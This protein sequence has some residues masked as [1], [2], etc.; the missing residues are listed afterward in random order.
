MNAK[1]SADWSEPTLRANRLLL[2]IGCNSNIFNLKKK[3]LLNSGDVITKM[4]HAL[5]E[6]D[7]PPSKEKK[8]LSFPG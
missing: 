5:N 3:H 2:S 8:K 7:L 6:L 1:P 4:L